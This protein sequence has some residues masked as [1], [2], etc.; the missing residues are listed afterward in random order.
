[1][2][3][4]ST[5][6]TVSGLTWS[7]DPSAGDSGIAPFLAR[8]I[9]PRTLEHSVVKSNPHRSVRLIKTNGSAYYL[10]EHRC[11]TL[12][13]RLRSRLFSTRASAEWH[14]IHTMRNL[15][16]HTPDPVAYAQGENASGLQSVLITKAITDAGNLREM[17]ESVPPEKKRVLA[18]SLGAQIRVLHDRGVYHRDLQPGNLF[19]AL[20]GDGFRF[21]F[22]DLHKAAFPGSLSAGQKIKDIGRLVFN[23][24]RFSSPGI[25]NSLLDGYAGGGDGKLG[26][27]VFREAW[28]LNEKRKRSRAGRCLRNS[29]H[30]AK[31]R[32]GSFRIFRRRSV[33]VSPLMDAL[34]ARKGREEAL[35]ELKRSKPHWHIKEIPSTG[36]WQNIKDFFQRPRGRRAWHAANALAVRGISTPEPLA[37]VEEVKTGMVKRSWLVTRHLEDAPTLAQYV[38]DVFVAKKSGYV[39]KRSFMLKLAAAISLLYGESIYHGD[40]KASNILVKAPD[41]WNAQFLFIDLDGNHLWRKPGP[42]RIVKNLVQLYCSLPFCVSQSMAAKFFVRFLGETGLGPKLRHRLPEI[43]SKARKRRDRWI[44]IVRKHGKIL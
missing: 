44:A 29:T 36:L 13:E 40:L 33:D 27:A 18:R 25:V 1:V 4:S 23:L 14:A 31:E 12:A 41:G 38:H 19:V 34:G 39:R 6:H 37:L 9:D 8:G 26:A 3:E 28:R 24:Q 35:A 5:K 2:A 42:S 43:I 15:G 11:V 32:S 16:F 10:K 20:D 21:Y 17:L 7:I 30:F 22:L